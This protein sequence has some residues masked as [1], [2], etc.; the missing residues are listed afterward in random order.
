MKR[1][2]S[3]LLMVS[4]GDGLPPL[5]KYLSETGLILF[6]IPVPETP[7]SPDGSVEARPFQ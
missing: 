3:C 4:E 1:I 7:L 5:E 6:S 2:V